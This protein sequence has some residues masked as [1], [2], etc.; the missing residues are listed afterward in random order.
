MPVEIIVDNADPGFAITGFWLTYSGPPYPAYNG[1]FRYH[2][3]GSG[4][5]TATFRPAVPAAGDYEVF[6][7]FGTSPYG[8]TN[9]P[10]T[11]N[12]DGG[13]HTVTV[14][15]LGPA[16]EGGYWLSLG[17]YPLAAGTAGTVVTTDNANGYVIADAIRLLQV[18]GP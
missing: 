7:W 16:G 11:V 18:G 1:S 3:A 17:V 10:W 9:A 2:A 5:N 8:A 12:Y 13:A 15:L 6:I 14:N 4:S